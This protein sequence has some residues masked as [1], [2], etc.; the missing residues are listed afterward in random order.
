MNLDK[1]IQLEEICVSLEEAQ[2]LNNSVNAAHAW[3]YN[4]Y[5]NMPE[6][7][8]RTV[9]HLILQNEEFIKIP[10]LKMVKGKWELWNTDAFVS[11]EQI[12]EL[13]NQ[14]VF[15]FAPLKSEIGKNI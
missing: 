14:K 10:G 12:K 11:M 13:I 8:L 6:F 9:E 1:I 3:V 2:E 7:E 5:K 4:K 15:Y